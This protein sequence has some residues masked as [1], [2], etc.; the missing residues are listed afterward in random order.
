MKVMR[1]CTT[2]FYNCRH[3]SIYMLHIYLR[4]ISKLKMYYIF[5]FLFYL[6]IFS[7]YSFIYLLIFL[8]FLLYPNFFLCFYLFIFFYLI[9]FLSFFIYY[10]IALYIGRSVPLSRK[11]SNL[12]FWCIG[13]YVR[14]KCNFHL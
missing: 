9:Y 13:Q 14:R 4:S 1:A 7:I 2:P 8:H 5:S 3:I 12:L 10:E 6:Q 11:S